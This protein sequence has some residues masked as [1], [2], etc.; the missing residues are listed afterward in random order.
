MTAPAL[1]FRDPTESELLGMGERKRNWKVADSISFPVYSDSGR[2]RRYRL[3][4]LREN[5]ALSDK[6]GWIA[7]APNL[8]TGRCLIAGGPYTLEQAMKWCQDVEN[9]EWDRL[10]SLVK[11]SHHDHR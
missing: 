8:A 4:H 10:K 3:A 11:G 9:A 5:N 7:F 1:E 2:P 6:S